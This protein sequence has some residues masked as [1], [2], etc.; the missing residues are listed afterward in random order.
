MSRDGTLLDLHTVEFKRLLP[1]PIEL[2]WDYLTKPELLKTWFADVTLEPSAGGA[3][4]VRFSEDTCGGHTGG[5][6]GIIREFR[7]PYV[8]VFS[9]I[10]RRTQPDGSIND[11]DE[12]EVRFELAERG[13][14]VLLTLLHS[15]L[16]TTELTS[17]GAGWHAYLDNLESRISGRERVDFMAVV[18]RVRPKY[19]ERVAAMLRSGAA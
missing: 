14:K 18:G 6:H 15:G 12:G 17:H 5:V 11:S 16:P 1:G 13:D 4:D 10:Q 2:A 3:V 19:E 7:P 9:W 8:I